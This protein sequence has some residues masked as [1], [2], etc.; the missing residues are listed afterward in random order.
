VNIIPEKAVLHISFRAPT[1]AEKET[2]E[3]KVVEIYKAA[4][5]ATGCQVLNYLTIMH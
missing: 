5:A 1:D 4:A 3:A 2:L